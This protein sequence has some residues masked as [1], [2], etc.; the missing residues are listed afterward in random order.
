MRGAAIQNS[1]QLA[2]TNPTSAGPAEAST[3]INSI[4]FGERRFEA[5]ANWLQ[6]VLPKHNCLLRDSAA[7]AAKILPASCD[8]NLER[9]REASWLKTTGYPA[10]DSAFALIVPVHN[11]E[12]ALP[13]MLDSLM[14][15]HF[16]LP[17]AVRTNFIFV[18]NGC[19]DNS[20]A[21]I[22]SNIAL[23]GWERVPAPTVVKGQVDETMYHL[24]REDSSFSL[25][26][27]IGRGKGRALNIGNKVALAAG[28]NIVLTMDANNW[29]EPDSLPKMYGEFRRATEHPNSPITV[30]DA[31]LYGRI[32]TIHGDPFNKL[33]RWFR[34][35]IDQTPVPRGAHL[36]GA[37]MAWK[38]D[39]YEKVGGTPPSA[40]TDYALTLLARAD[41]KRFAHGHAHIW[42]YVPSSF[43]D[44]FSARVRSA[45]S[46]FALQKIFA[47]NPA[48][49]KML[50][51]DSPFLKPASERLKLS[52]LEALKRPNRIPL[53]VFRYLTVEAALWRAKHPGKISMDPACWEALAST[54]GIYSSKLQ[55]TY[56]LISRAADLLLRRNPENKTTQLRSNQLKS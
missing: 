50:R 23:P 34:G 52:L 15:A 46:R 17:K 51:E 39:W 43:R 11:E 35:N 38:A 33:L 19:T 14:R 26:N 12:T 48:I 21:S 9:A 2:N 45:R 31:R 5:P 22:I 32:R 13:S 1:H 4:N 16:H 18:T 3:K 56:A 42:T 8:P 29:L 36:T 10:K 54:K 25:L 44:W 7:G 20:A 41:G 47:D 28:L 6:A 55:S 49:L 30:M 53:T 27:L 24:Q 37:Y 40:G